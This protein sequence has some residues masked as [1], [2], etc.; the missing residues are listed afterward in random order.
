MIDIGFKWSKAQEYEC[1]EIDGV[2]AIRQKGAQREKP[3]EP[4]MIDGNK[5]LYARF[6]DLNGK[7]ISSLL[8]FANAWGLLTTEAPGQAERLDA[9]RNEIRKMKGL[10]N[11]LRGQDDVPGGILRMKPGSR[12]T[13][14]ALPPIKVTLVPGE[15]DVDGMIGRPKLVLGPSNL[16]D[17]MYLQLGKFVSSEGV[18][19]RCR[20]C[21]ELFEC[22]AVET[23]RSIALFCK[24]Q[25][26]DRYNYLKRKAS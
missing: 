22:G 10:T 16:L 14:V 9:W 13:E 2:K 11:V 8:E 24:P 15:V 4:L 7:E 20:H 23:R 12:G 18:L 5:P 3:K 19:R 1:V 25:C 21:K 26:K 17:A 6:A